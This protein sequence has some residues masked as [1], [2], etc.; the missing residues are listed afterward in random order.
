MG[1][2]F[3][4]VNK[5]DNIVYL[6]SLSKMA[7]INRILTKL[8]MAFVPLIMKFEPIFSIYTEKVQILQ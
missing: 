4:G 2:I 1:V 7:Q 3:Q 5:V 8:K 6:S